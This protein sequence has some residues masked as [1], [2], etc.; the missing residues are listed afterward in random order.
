MSHMV[1][2]LTKSWLR[3][4]PKASIVLDLLLDSMF[5]KFPILKHIY[6]YHMF[7]S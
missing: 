2:T 7:Y 6:Y 4:I 5:H 1:K 3:L